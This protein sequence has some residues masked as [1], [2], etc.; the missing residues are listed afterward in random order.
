VKPP[1]PF[2]WFV[3]RSLGRKIVTDLSADGF[4]VKKHCATSQMTRRTLEQGNLKAAQMAQA[5]IAATVWPERSG[6]LPRDG[7]LGAVPGHG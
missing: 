4:K 3:D 7:C 2:T 6:V 5:F 1:E